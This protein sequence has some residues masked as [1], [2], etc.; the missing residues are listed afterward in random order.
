MTFTEERVLNGDHWTFR[1]I[2]M[3]YFGYELDHPDRWKAPSQDHTFIRRALER[4]DNDWTSETPVRVPMSWTSCSSDP[5]SEDATGDFDFPY[6]WQ[7]VHKGEY[8]TTFDIPESFGGKRI[9]LQFMSVNFKCW[10]YVNGTLAVSDPACPAYTHLNKHP[11]EVDITG[12]VQTPSSGN[13][14]TVVVQ[15]F[16]A[17]FSGC[18]PNEDK[19]DTPEDGTFYP[20]GDRSEYYN[21]DRGWRNLDTGLIDDVILK[22]VPRLHVQ[23][24]YVVTSVSEGDIRAQVTVR[25]EDDGDRSFR[26]QANVHEHLGGRHSLSFEPTAEITVPAG[27]SVTVELH[28]RWDDPT[29]WWP[30][31]PFLYDLR[32]ELAQDEGVVASSATRFGFRQVEVVK[33]ED[34]D[35]RGIYL[36]GRRV[37]LFGE[38]VEPT[39]KDG[40]TEGVGTSGLY[41]YNAQYWTH[42]IRTAKAMNIT[43]LRTHRG[44][45]V[46]RLFEIADEEGMLMIAESTINNGNHNGAIGTMDSQRTA[47]R[48]MIVTLRNHPSIIIWSLANESGYNEQWADEA[49]LHDRSRLLVVTQAKPRYPSASMAAAGVSYAFGLNGYSPDIYERHNRDWKPQPVYVYE[50]NA[51]YDQPTDEERAG[52]VLQAMTIFRGHR[53]TGYEI[54]CTYYSFQ[55]AFGQGTDPDAK[56]LAI[57]WSAD[58]TG[59]RGYYPDFA[60]M[61]LHDPWTNRHRP[62]VL[63]PIEGFADSPADY[64]TRSFSPVAVFDYDYDKRLSVQAS[65]EPYVGLFAAERTVAVHNDDWLDDSTLVT[66]RYTAVC[67]DSGETL[68]EGSFTLDVPLGGTRRHTYT[69]RVDGSRRVRIDYAALKADAVRFRETIYL[70]P[71]SET[72]GG[73]YMSAPGGDEITLDLAAPEGCAYDAHAVQFNPWIGRSGDYNVYVRVSE[74]AIRAAEATGGLCKI[75]VQHDTVNTTAALRL[76]EGVWLPVSQ[77]PLH[78]NA[79]RFE[80]NIKLYMAPDQLAGS[81]IAVKLAYAGD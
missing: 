74:R 52:A 46:K 78:M 6:F 4:P 70:G 16:T 68:D 2:A 23:D 12:L 27:Q 28:Q 45:W 1:P 57:R 14:L 33:S 26:I 37:R 53:T 49:R 36:N 58:E 39:R 20:L 63:N 71:P 10:V 19:P 65:A 8:A 80:N 21:K 69:L 35:A 22:A 43:V 15:D 61:P 13:R 38:S 17:A 40:Y 77:H 42:L 73:T 79:G 51:C 64:W 25:N 44:M 7:Y 72:C 11:F 67:P 76:A 30:H 41:L 18:F 60:V 31:R 24:A 59:N 75:E 66:V 56:R 55:K 29:L 48:D 54:I 81:D 47:I 34:D 3:D 62:V 32:L 9:K 5:L 50:D